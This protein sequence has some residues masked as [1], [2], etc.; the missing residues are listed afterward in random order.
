MA[1]LERQD[2]LLHVCTQTTPC[3][4]RRIDLNGDGRQ[5]LLVAGSRFITAY[6]LDDAGQWRRLAR[7]TIPCDTAEDALDAEMTKGVVA[8]PST[9][10]DLI[11]GGRKLQAQ[12]ETDCD[13]GRRG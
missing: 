2:D 13:A 5:D 8:A 4:S 11:V 9:L 12:P 1:Q 7:Y 6:G 10:P 3:L